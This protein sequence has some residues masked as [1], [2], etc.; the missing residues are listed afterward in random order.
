MT[1]WTAGV[2]TVAQEIPAAGTNN[3]A[4]AIAAS[5][6]AW[7]LGAVV[8]AT[9]HPGAKQELVNVYKAPVAVWTAGVNTIKQFVP[10]AGT[11]NFAVAIAAS[12]SAWVLGAVVALAT[13]RGK[14]K[15][16]TA[17]KDTTVKKYNLFIFTSVSPYQ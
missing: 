12:L 16:I 10:A 8:V 2:N 3:L 1:V 11:N 5:L 13:K 7:V 6:S 9:T 4:A 15:K 17:T 14:T